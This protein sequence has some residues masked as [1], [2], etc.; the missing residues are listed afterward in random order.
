MQTHIQGE[1]N[2]Q[3]T[4]A[5]RLLYYTASGEVPYI[6]NTSGCRLTSVRCLLGK[7]TTFII[8]LST[9][10]TFTVTSTLTY[11][12]LPTGE[13][14]IFAHPVLSIEIQRIM[15][16]YKGLNMVKKNSPPFVLNFK[17]MNIV[18]NQ[19]HLSRYIL[20]LSSRQWWNFQVV[21]FFSFHHQKVFCITLLPYSCHVRSTWQHPKLVSLVILCGRYKSRSST[22]RNFLR[23]SLT[24]SILC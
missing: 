20:I 6:W 4:C 23:P 15:W 13:S 22:S 21:P 8:T 11:I 12:L 7:I 10:R 24:S 17:Q 2:F 16:L 19:V 9:A 18:L 5:R 1:R 14:E 3:C